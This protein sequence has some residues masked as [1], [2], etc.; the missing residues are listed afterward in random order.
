LSGW[1]YLGATCLLALTVG[2]ANATTFDW[3][4]S[5]A[6]ANH[7]YITGSGT[8]TATDEGGGQYLV[9]TISGSVSDSC[10]GLPCLPQFTSIIALLTPGQAYASF[11][12]VPGDNLIFYPGSPFLGQ[13]LTNGIVFSIVGA[14]QTLMNISYAPNVLP[15]NPQYSL[16]LSNSGASYV[17]FELTPEAAAPEPATWVMLLVGIGGFGAALRSRRRRGPGLGKA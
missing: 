13:G 14:G 7:P 16:F 4:F 15:G 17:D 3:S 1:N 6:A 10:S 9:D 11:T 12:T 8:L 2:S 5:G